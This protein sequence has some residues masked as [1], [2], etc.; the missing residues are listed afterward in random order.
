ML[1]FVPF[2]VSEF[3]SLAPHAEAFLVERLTYRLE[4]GQRRHGVGT[5]AT[6]QDSIEAAGHTAE[7]KRLKQL[8]QE[9]LFRFVTTQDET[10]MPPAAA[11]EEDTLLGGTNESCAG[12]QDRN[13]HEYYH[14]A[15]YGAF[16]PGSAIELRKLLVA[17]CVTD[18]ITPAFGRR[19]EAIVHSMKAVDDGHRFRLAYLRKQWDMQMHHSDTFALDVVLTLPPLARKQRRRRRLSEPQKR[20]LAVN[21]A[22]V[23]DL[24]GGK[25]ASLRPAW[26][27]P[28]VNVFKLAGVDAGKHTHK[29]GDV[30]M[31]LDKSIG[32]K[33]LELRGSIP[34]RNFARLPKPAS[35]TLGL[36]GRFC[37]VQIKPEPGK[38][39]AFHLDVQTGDKYVHRISIGNMY[40]KRVAGV[41]GI[42]CQF[43]AP[44]DRWVTLVVD[45][46]TI[47]QPGTM[48]PFV[49]LKAA[50]FSA[51]MRVR[52]LF[53]SDLKFHPKNLP[54]ARP[55]APFPGATPR[56]AFPADME[57]G[58]ALW[59][60]AG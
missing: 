57:A 30:A 58:M 51:S 54:K 35:K 34:S 40:Q 55:C 46:A 14:A 23:S 31:V 19:L 26:E 20:A 9:R 29:E 44:P 13:V 7:D 45:F 16:I 60:A 15:W 36:T 42:Q 22:A 52:N 59:R 41:R 1:R 5:T 4:D 12:G 33:V 8:I 11:G 37:Y 2:A 48:H 10:L 17:A 18:G 6:K 47:L 49:H 53:T 21:A 43:D 28:F 38:K 32:K 24:G 25:M 56:D 3:G 39:W 27:L 50:Q